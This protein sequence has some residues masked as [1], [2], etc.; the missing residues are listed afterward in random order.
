[1]SRPQ[2]FVL[3][4]ALLAAGCGRAEDGAALVHGTLYQGGSWETSFELSCGVEI[5]GARPFRLRVFQ[6]DGSGGEQGRDGL[7]VG[8]SV[9]ISNS[10]VPSDGVPLLL[11]SSQAVVRSVRPASGDATVSTD[12]RTSRFGDGTL[13]A[14]PSTGWLRLD[15]DSREPGDGATGAFELRFDTGEVVSGT[16][17]GAFLD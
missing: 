3:V 8:R 10:Q 9:E 17:A 6:P 15:Y 12:G 16:F 11:D 5:H 4:L 2:R 1:V 13:V 7:P 14:R